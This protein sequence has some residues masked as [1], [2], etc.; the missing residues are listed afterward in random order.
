MRWQRKSV[1]TQKTGGPKVDPASTL[2]NGAEINNLNDLK[3]ALYE[4]RSQFVFA[5]TEKLMTFA[6]GREMT[7]KEH[8]EIKRIA[9]LKAAENYGFRDLVLAVI[10]SKIFIQ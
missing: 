8:A 9:N 7:F 10:N 3:K 1:V 6:T 2:P 4:R 5:L